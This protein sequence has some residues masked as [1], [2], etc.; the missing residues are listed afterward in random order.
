MDPW[1]DH[2]KKSS[3]DSSQTFLEEIYKKSPADLQCDAKSNNYYLVPL[4]VIHGCKNS[5]LEEATVEEMENHDHEDETISSEIIDAFQKSSPDEAA[6]KMKAKWKDYENVTLNIAIT[7][8]TGAGKSTFVNAIRGLRND[9][10]GAAPTD[11][12]ECTKYPTVYPHPTLPNVNIWDLPGMGTKQFRA[13]TYLKDVKWDR[14]DFFLILS[15]ERFKENDSNLA[16]AIKEKKKLY[17]F[18][19]TKIDNDIQSESQKRSYNEEQMLKNIRDDCEKNLTVKAGGKPKVFLISS[20]HLEKYDFPKLIRTLEDELPDNKLFALIQSL[21][22]HSTEAL[23]RKKK[24]FRKLIWMSAFGSGVLAVTPIPGLSLACDYGILRSFFENVYKSFGLDEKSLELLS[25]RVN[26]PVETL[27]AAKESRFK[28]GVNEEMLVNML[29]K[30]IVVAALTIEQLSSFVIGIGSLTA[31]GVS[32][33]TIY[34]LLKKGLN[35]MAEDTKRILTVA[36]LA[37]LV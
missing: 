31:G 20:F 7:G 22:V 1:K 21:P 13:K 4:D 32:I 5:T 23:E 10:E 33:A 3:K 14:Y 26:K 18:V 9:D 16:K 34:H 17:Y 28:D 30:P 29:K 8:M 35:E 19:R 27:K 12:V 25:A 15:S 36:E 37:E 11:A 24:Y 6:E 2:K